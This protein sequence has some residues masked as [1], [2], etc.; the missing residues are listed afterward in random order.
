MPGF[1]DFKTFFAQ[2]GERVSIIVF[3]SLGNQAAWRNDPQHRE[4]QRRGRDDFYTTYSIS[5]CEELHESGFD[6]P[7]QAA[8]DQHSS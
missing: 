6:P 5:V 7:I 4:A 3:D 1:I 8:E 2:D